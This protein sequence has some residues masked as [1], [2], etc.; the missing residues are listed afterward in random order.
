MLS[1]FGKSKLANS[2]PFR[3]AIHWK[4]EEKPPHFLSFSIPRVGMEC[5]VISG[6]FWKRLSQGGGMEC[7]V[8]K[9]PCFD[10]GAGATLE[11]VF[12]PGFLLAGDSGASEIVSIAGFFSRSR[13][14][15]AAKW[16]RRHLI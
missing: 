4:S 5:G 16:L 8:T 11:I 3:E 10:A 6:Q 15:T 2:I 7:G 1:I 14:T 13:V 12:V 9:A